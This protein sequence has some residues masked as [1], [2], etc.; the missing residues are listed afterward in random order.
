MICPQYIK[1]VVE[2]NFSTICKPSPRGFEKWTAFINDHLPSHADHHIDAKFSGVFIRLNG[3][4]N[5]QYRFANGALGLSPPQKMHFV[6]AKNNLHWKNN[7]ANYFCEKQL[8]ADAC[9][10]ESVTH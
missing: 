1:C 5:C 2:K 4:M 7:G 9:V 3:P 6:P 8:K 10:F